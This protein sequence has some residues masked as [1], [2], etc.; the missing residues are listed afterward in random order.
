MDDEQHGQHHP[1]RSFEELI[2]G[3]YTHEEGVLGVD[4]AEYNKRMREH[5]WKMA[6]TNVICNQA[7]AHS[8]IFKAK[9]WKRA[10]MVVDL[11]LYAGLVYAIVY[12]WNAIF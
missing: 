4:G 2:E 3:A 6:E 8:A 11:A 5:N 1:P 12:A 7:H 9:L 10:S